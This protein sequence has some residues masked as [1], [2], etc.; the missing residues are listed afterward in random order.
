[1]SSIIHVQIIEAVG[2]PVMDRVSELTD[3]FAEI[4][5]G[6]HTFKTKVVW[7][8]LNPVFD[9]EWF[10]FQVLDE[11]LNLN[12]LHIRLMDYDVYTS[13]D[14][15]GKVSISLS[16]LALPNS[17]NFLAGWF[18]LY[19]TMHGNRGYIRIAVKFEMLG[20]K[21]ESYT[22]NSFPLFTYDSVPFGYELVEIHGLLNSIMVKNDTEDNWIDFIRSSRSSNEARQSL[23]R[24]LSSRLTRKLIIKALNIGGNAICGFKISLEV[25]GES[26]VIARALGTCVTIRPNQSPYEQTLLNPFIES[27]ALNEHTNRRNRIYRGSMANYNNDYYFFD[28]DTINMDKSLTAL[29][30]KATMYGNDAY[31]VLISTFKIFPDKMFYQDA[32]MII[33]T[34]VRL[35]EHNHSEKTM[36]TKKRWWEEL[37]TEMKRKAH[38]MNCNMIGGYSEVFT[39]S[40]KFLIMIAYGTALKTISDDKMF[41]SFISIYFYFR[42]FVHHC[43]TSHIPYDLNSPPFQMKFTECKVCKYFIICF[44]LYCFYL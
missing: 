9:R 27:C 1:M 31:N 44:N 16:P 36:K 10:K 24:D 5:F 41:L 25:E 40:G 21:I 11:E 43:T 32:S 26:S 7:K 6:P 17:R 8:T 2:L 28:P 37:R 20:N 35:A 19:D 23:F 18:P 4:K 22:T 39:I 42:N 14:V 33:T 12:L 13:H 38:N 3:A 34:A 29:R 30:K 15:V